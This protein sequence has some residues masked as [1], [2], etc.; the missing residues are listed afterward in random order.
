M[1]E[2]KLTLPVL[3]ALKSHGN[4]EWRALARKVKTCQASKDD[5]S[6]LVE[7]TKT[8]GGIE[9]SYKV[10]E[11]FSTQARALISDFR[12][13]EIKQALLSYIDYVSSRTI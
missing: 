13:E 6:R 9:D 11:Q 5:I 10:M 4:D 12:Q 7:F 1:A 3:L 2:G 8:S